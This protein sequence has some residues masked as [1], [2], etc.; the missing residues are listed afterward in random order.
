MVTSGVRIACSCCKY[1]YCW[2]ISRNPGEIVKGA[3]RLEGDSAGGEG[4]DEES[5][6]GLGA[7]APFTCCRRA[8]TWARFSCAGDH[9]PPWSGARGLE[10][11]RSRGAPPHDLSTSRGSRWRSGTG[12]LD[13]AGLACGTQSVCYYGVSLHSN[14]IVNTRSRVAALNVLRAR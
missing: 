12:F 4:D 3:G 10:A 11:D 9:D 7:C 13:F 8:S 5:D 14:Y 6:D 2:A 1:W